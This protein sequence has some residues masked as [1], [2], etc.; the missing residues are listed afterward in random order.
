MF[1]FKRDYEYLR[2]RADALKEQIKDQRKIYE[3]KIEDLIKEKNKYKDESIIFFH[4]LSILPFS[5]FIISDRF[6]SA[7][8]L[9]HPP[10][11]IRRNNGS[12]VL[13]LYRNSVQ[14]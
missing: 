7:R 3:D 12:K 14:A 2:D 4:N 10:C 13:P 8:P 9:H 11:L 5:N 6:Y 1:L